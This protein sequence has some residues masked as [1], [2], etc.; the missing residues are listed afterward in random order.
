MVIKSDIALTHFTFLAYLDKLIKSEEGSPL[1]DESSFKKNV[2][3]S[4]WEIFQKE[5]S[6]ALPIKSW[7]EEY[8]ER[9]SELSSIEDKDS[10]LAAL[11]Y[12]MPFGPFVKQETDEKEDKR[13]ENPGAYREEHGLAPTMKSHH[14]EKSTELGEDE[15]LVGEPAAQAADNQMYSQDMATCK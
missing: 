3:V 11:W 4:C 8:K 7:W 9:V 10:F 6:K 2:S 1:W 5:I 15:N 13:A 14:T 12:D